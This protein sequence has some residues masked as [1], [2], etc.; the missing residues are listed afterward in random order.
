[1]N[2][3]LKRV[4]AVLLIVL[5]AFGWYTMLNGLGSVEAFK[6]KIQLG[7]D[8]K[9][10]VYVVM[11]AETD[12]QGEELT[13][14][15]NQTKEVITRRVDQMGVANADVRVEGKNRIR[16]ELPGAENAQDA[17]DQI[18]K[19]A[20]LKFTLA[21]GS[22]V[23]DG[24]DVK[25]ATIAQDQNSTGYVVNLE[26]KSSGAKAFEKAT[27]SSS[28]GTVNPTVE[29]DDGTLVDAQS[30]VITLDDDIISAPT[31]KSVISGG[32]C[33]ISGSFDKQ[34]A[35]ELAALIRGGALPAPL[36]EVTSSTQTAQIGFNAFSK[37]VEAGI[38]GVLLIFLIMLLGYRVMGF[39]ADIALAMYIVIVLYIMGI[40]GSVLTLSGIAGIILS[41]GMAVDANV[42][43]FSRIKEEIRVGK[44]V[45]VA[46]Q[47]GF[48]RAMGTVID[49][50]ITTLIAAIILYQVGTSTVKG[51]AFTLMI[52]II[53]S[54][55]TAV[56]VTQ[57][58]LSIFAD[59]KR[60]GTKKMFGINEN[61]QGFFEKMREF[62]FIKHRRKYFAVSA[63]IIVI[64]LI[65][66]VTKG[67]SY[68][69]DFTGGTMMQIDMN[70]HV[71][72]Q[73]IVDDLAKKDI[74]AQVVYSG[75]EEEE[76][77]IKTVTA[78]DN[79]QRAEVI[80]DLQKEYGFSDED[81]LSTE[82]FGPS[83]GKELKTN[84]L[85]AILIAA[86]GMLLYIRLRFKE[87]KFGAA[88]LIGVLHDVLMLLSFYVIFGIT[89]N[90]P[91]IA[92]ILTVV[93]YSI[94]DTIVIFD[95]IRENNKFSKSGNEVDIINHSINQ[96]LARS[97]M[98]SLT[99]LVVMVPLFAMSSSSLREFTLPLMVGIMAGTLSSIFICS[100]L[101][102]IFA[103]G[104]GA[105]K[106]ERQLAAAKKAQKNTNGTSAKNEI[107]HKGH[108]KQS[109]EARKNNK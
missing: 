54:I 91:F 86:I 68:G 27:E 15:M 9:G 75:S 69:I 40:F 1:M 64:A 93:G 17:I 85:K 14:L 11:E 12:L 30:I 45:R 84:A 65:F 107:E 6:D 32:K 36:T 108:K 16:V 50:Q 60:W 55:I 31:A 13:Q 71:S 72:S 92:G 83:I 94:N 95:R 19:T 34:G 24:G 23:L 46:V 58:F 18:G 49:S 89:V 74:E 29:Y 56:V 103:S 28:S 48:K 90:N 82:L 44:S 3:K 59:S 47:I 63:T 87:W 80:S 100:P 101:Y 35:T 73:D 41:I 39:A 70:K 57:I 66:S 97:I 53:V 7:L 99:T 62:D 78:L 67:F 109:R 52:G 51:F 25:N 43:I 5:L 8:I 104:K 42:I 98:T 88:A 33:E 77:I 21:D 22:Y 10:G 81:V 105:S 106:Y 20:Q 26:F 2:E 76:V 61:K 38:I 96:T 102:Y 37:S 4:I 79:D